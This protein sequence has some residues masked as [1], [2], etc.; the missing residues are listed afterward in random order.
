LYIYSKT[1]FLFIVA[2]STAII[3]HL[4]PHLVPPRQLQKLDTGEKIKANISEARDAFV[5]HVTVRKVLLICLIVFLKTHEIFE[6]YVGND[7]INY[8][9]NK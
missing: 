1:F 6:K 4:L 3:L 5:F 9:T 2:K 8:F 7:L